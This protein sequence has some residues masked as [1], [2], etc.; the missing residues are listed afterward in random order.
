MSNN[1]SGRREI[2]ELDEVPRSSTPE[3][4]SK[5][6]RRSSSTPQAPARDSRRPGKSKARATEDVI[7][8]AAGESEPGRASNRSSSRTPDVVRPVPIDGSGRSPDVVRP[9][10]IDGSGLL[11]A[12][13][14]PDPIDGEAY[15]AV[16]GNQGAELLPE[17]VRP[18]P[19]DGSGLLPAVE[20]PDPI[21]G[22]AYA[23]VI[24]NDGRDPRTLKPDGTRDQMTSASDGR[25]G[26]APRTMVVERSSGEETVASGM[27]VGQRPSVEAEPATSRMPTVERP[28]PIDGEVYAA[29]V[30]SDPHA[31]IGAHPLVDRA[32]TGVLETLDAPAE[33]RQRSRTPSEYRALAETGTVASPVMSTVAG[34]PTVERT[35]TG[36]LETAGSTLALVAE[37]PRGEPTMVDTFTPPVGAATQVP[38]SESSP[39]GRGRPPI[40]WGQGIPTRPSTT[41]SQSP[42]ASSDRPSSRPTVSQESFNDTIARLQREKTRVQ[43]ELD[44]RKADFI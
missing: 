28:D 23:A 19:I 30:A 3:P 40:G 15:A 33:P 9:V 32:S 31:A 11:P 17:V 22:E 10:P 20:R 13:E 4:V 42:T 24:G 18:D 35:L 39:D 36:V 6:P 7:A 14:R 8:S 16:M 21:D 12:V 27:R 37:E 43:R 26:S 41:T 25:L 1:P 2:I 5:R 29:G 38:T 44:N 34:G